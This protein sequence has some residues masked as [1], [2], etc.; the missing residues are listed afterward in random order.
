MF[1][2]LGLGIRRRNKEVEE[3]MNKDGILC[4]A[5]YATFSVSQLLR[6]VNI[7]HASDGFR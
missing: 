7:F 4:V 6:A 5:Q 1:R 2:S 3:E